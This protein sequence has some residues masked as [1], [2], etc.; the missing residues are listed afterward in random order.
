MTG[1]FA[2]LISERNAKVQLMVSENKNCSHL[3]LI[4]SLGGE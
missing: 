2:T 1:L 4:C 3:G